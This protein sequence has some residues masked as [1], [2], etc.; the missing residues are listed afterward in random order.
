VRVGRDDTIAVR[1]H[2][3]DKTG[4]VLDLVA[5]A[6]RLDT[7]RDF[8]AVLEAA[9][10]LAGRYDLIGNRDEP[11]PSSP[12]ARVSPPET[13]AD[14]ERSY[15]PIEE[16]SALWLACV[17]CSDQDD[18]S[19]LLRERHLDPELVD[20]FALARAI[21][22]CAPLPR[23]ARYRGKRDRAA[24]WAETGHRL[25]VPVFDA[26]G[27]MRSVRAWC[28]VKESSDPKRL[29]PA[30]HRSSGLVMADMWARAIL[31]GNRRAPRHV[32][33]TEGEPDFLTWGTRF[34]DANE[35][36]PAVIGIMSGAW[37]PEIAARIPDGAR[38]AVRTDPDAS[39]RKYARQIV[40]SLSSRCEVFTAEPGDG[41]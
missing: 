2:A 38:V 11:F 41:T 37:T 10:R 16:V 1:C 32:L 18:V 7:R 9:A 27:V 12:R 31:A 13:V 30:G 35:D 24:S 26:H 20:L 15:P 6:H 39:G 23:W 3:C 4:D 5:V 25:V 22:R 8:R 21:P 34:S 36:A 17:P 28:T 33:V 40:R 19:A 29:P 14:A